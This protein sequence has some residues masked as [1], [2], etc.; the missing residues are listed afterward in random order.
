VTF[1]TACSIPMPVVIVLCVSLQ[2]LVFITDQ[3]RCYLPLVLL[4][5]FFIPT[6]FDSNAL[7]DSLQ[8]VTE[9]YTKVAV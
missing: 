9:R 5:R 4:R 6:K 8:K 3:S 1:V 2:G 7:A